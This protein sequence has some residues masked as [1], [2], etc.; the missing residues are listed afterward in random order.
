MILA[1]S[2]P[3]F[4]AGLDLLE[5]HQPEEQRL[6]D[7]WTA[8][9]QVYLDL[10]GSRLATIAGISGPAPAA[11]CMLAM[12]CDYRIMN[13]KGIIG[14]N[15]AQFGLTA[16]PWMADL[17]LKTVGH[18]QAEKA[19]ML[20]TLY[21]AKDALQIGLVDEIVEGDVMEACQEQAIR[22]TRIPPHSRVASKLLLR[23]PQLD[24]LAA[25]RQ[26]DLDLFVKICLSGAVQKN[27]GLYLESLKKKGK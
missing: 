5:M 3:V 22:W 27:L 18:R 21:P 26:D 8:L 4:S 1:S 10:Y 2:T 16:P 24:L 9:Q 6:R 17:M 15:E 11:G 12:A 14:L 13:P 7:F 23:K 19:L 25:T 20:G